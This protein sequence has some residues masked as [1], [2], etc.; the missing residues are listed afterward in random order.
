VTTGCGT[1][2]GVRD[3][4]GDLTVGTPLRTFQNHVRARLPVTGVPPAPSDRSETIG[5]MPRAQD[6][7]TADATTATQRS[8]RGARRIPGG[9]SQGAKHVSGH[10]RSRAR[11]ADHPDPRDQ[12]E[13]AAGSESPRGGRLAP[14]VPADFEANGDSARGGGQRIG[15]AR[16]STGKQDLALQLDALERADCAGIFADTASGSLRNRPELEKCLDYL[17][18]GDTLLVWKLDR[19]G[20]SHRHLLDTVA[21]LDQR[22]IAFRSLHDPIDTTTP[23]GKL[24]FNLFAALAEFDR[25]VIRER[26]IAGMQAAI[27]RGRRPGR[28]PALSDEQ[29][30][31]ARAM[32]AAGE[33]KAAVARSLRVGRTTLYRHLTN[34]DHVAA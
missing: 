27:A 1:G 25:D 18:A 13:I 15:Y 28:K 10:A 4:A 5:A 20:R 29:L 8:G 30:R 2:H 19:L 17:R 22:E 9:A 24:V 11:A 32:I 33:P 14:A 26:T 3:K 21:E 7:A 12:D 6:T 16:V 23:A 34:G 31:Q